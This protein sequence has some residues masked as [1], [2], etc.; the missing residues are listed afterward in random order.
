M[1]SISPGIVSVPVDFTVTG[2][3]GQIE[4]YTWSFSDNTPTQRGSTATHVFTKSGTY[5]IHLTATYADGTQKEAISS[6]IVT[7][8]E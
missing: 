6:F 2:E 4:S 8:S 1:P 7:A 3:S 5:E